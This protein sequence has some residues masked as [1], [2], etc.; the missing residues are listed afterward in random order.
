M[1]RAFADRAE[2]LGDEDFNV[3]MPLEK[4]TSKSFAKK[5][6][7]HIDMTKASVSDSTK[8]GQIYDGQSTTHFSVVDKN[9]NAVSL[10]YTLEHSYGSGLGTSK[11]GFIFN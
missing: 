2:Y 9:G 4:L 11:L 8:F 6:L 3:D 10:I 1:R 5:R 7:E